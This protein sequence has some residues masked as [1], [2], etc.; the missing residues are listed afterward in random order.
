VIEPG[1]KPTRQTSIRRMDPTPYRSA[2]LRLGQAPAD[3][4][5]VHSAC[6]LTALVSGAACLSS[7]LV[8]RPEWL[9]GLDALIARLAT[10]AII[11]LSVV[12]CVTCANAWRNEQPPSRHTRWLSFAALVVAVVIQLAQMH[13]LCERSSPVPPSYL[14]PIVLLPGALALAV[15]SVR[16]EAWEGAAYGIASFAVLL[17]G[18]APIAE[19]IHGWPDG[20][21][22]GAGVHVMVVATAAIV[23]AWALAPLSRAHELG[24]LAGMASLALAV[25]G[26]GMLGAA[27]LDGVRPFACV[28]DEILGRE[29]WW[30]TYFATQHVLVLAALA[31]ALPAAAFASR[32]RYA[33]GALALVALE[34]VQRG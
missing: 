16:R 2:P 14:V 11:A 29:C 28:H 25:D 33:L 23:A 1:T 8:V 26:L 3:T 6:C 24:S 34:F 5:R 21:S 15:L 7:L 32:R 13:R 31:I 19:T 9:T 22:A 4:R 20:A 10:N 12:V 17:A 27:L 18:S 30:E